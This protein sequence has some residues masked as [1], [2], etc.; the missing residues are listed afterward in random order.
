M[1][2]ASAGTACYRYVPVAPATVAS[3]DE[4]RIRITDDAAARISKDLGAY[5]TE[6]DGQWAPQGRDSVSIAIPIERTYHGMTVGSTS[7][8]LYLGRTEVVEVRKREFDRARTVLL[9]AGIV[10]GFGVLAAGIV[11]LADPNPDSQE[12]PPPP[13]PT[14]SRIP[15]SHLFTVRIPI[16]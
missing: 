1:V 8:V 13:P 7:Q 9:S 2:A 4:V 6:I 12:P 15:I 10:A 14:P 3:N 11:Q 16:P 5:L